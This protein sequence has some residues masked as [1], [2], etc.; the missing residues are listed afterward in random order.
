MPSIEQDKNGPL[1]RECC[2][3]GNEIG[4]YADYY[5]N[6]KFKL[7]CSVVC[8]VNHSKGAINGIQRAD[9]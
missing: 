3:C 8:A 6:K 1:R 4:A 7:F 9:I 5:R 2:Q